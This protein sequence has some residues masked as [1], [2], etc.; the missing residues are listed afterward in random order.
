M[1]AYAVLFLLEKWAFLTVIFCPEGQ[2]VGGSVSTTSSSG[3][4]DGDEALV[5]E[6]YQRPPE[7]S[8]VQSCGLAEHLPTELG[9]AAVPAEQKSSES[10]R[11]AM[12]GYRQ[13][14]REELV[15]IEVPVARHYETALSS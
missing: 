6:S 7:I 15:E 2:L 14:R 9:A 4:D 5:G 1:T 3:V 10:K 12:L 8:P 13:L 11:E